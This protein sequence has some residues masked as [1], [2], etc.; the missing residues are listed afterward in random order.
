MGQRGVL[1]LI[2]GSG[3]LPFEVARA[4]ARRGLSVAVAAI[5]RNTDPAIQAL[6]T[7]PFE[8]FAAGELG[9]LIAFFRSAGATE[10]ILAGAVSKRVLM[11]DP[12]ALRLDARAMTVLGRLAHRG[13]DA[14]LRAVADEIESEG[15]AV[16]DST[17]YL[18]DR[19]TAEGLLAGAAVDAR[20]ESDLVLAMRVARDVGVHDVGQAVAVRDGVVLAIEAIEGTDAMLRRAGELGGPG[21]VAVKVAKP[22][23]DLR[24]DVPAIGLGTIRLAAEIGLRAL[25]LEANRT[26]VLEREIALAEADRSGVSVIGMRSV[27]S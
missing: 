5:E 4:A 7:G 16:V 6:A 22:G 27:G 23:Q 14:L 19:L 25:G 3:P 26:I 8:W 18:G 24:F 17:A 10:V 9:R 2:A 21:A 15:M 20:I 1:G 13:D 11:R 12:A